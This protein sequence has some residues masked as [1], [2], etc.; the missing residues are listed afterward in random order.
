MDN[1]KLSEQW[2]V[3]LAIQSRLKL[4]TIHNSLFTSLFIIVP[5]A[6]AERAV[7]AIAFA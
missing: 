2:H 5:C 4:F 6:L 7:A 3:S 1:S